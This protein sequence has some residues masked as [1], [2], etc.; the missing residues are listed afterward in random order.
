MRNLH[1]YLEVNETGSLDKPS[2]KKK[3]WLTETG[4]G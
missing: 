2:C 3:P 1:M 4:V